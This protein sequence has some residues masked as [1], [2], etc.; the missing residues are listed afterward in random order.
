MTEDGKPLFDMM[1][2]PLVVMELIVCKC[3]RMCKGTEC[4]GFSNAHMLEPVNCNNLIDGDFEDS[5]D[6][7][8]DEY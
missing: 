2:D 3:N 6:D 5:G 7:T 4:Q 1:S 8:G